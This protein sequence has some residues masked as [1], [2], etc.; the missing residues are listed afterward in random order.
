MPTVLDSFIVEFGLDPSKFTQGQRDVL[1]QVRKL[2]EQVHKQST[3]AESD[4]KKT[5]AMFTNL[6][7]EAL[8]VLS[9]FFGGKEVGEF[10][11][12]ITD[13][14]ASTGRLATT[15]GMSAQQVSAWQGAIR[16]T[17][18]SAEEANGALAGLSAEISRFSMTGRS[19]ML[20]VLARLGIDL[21]DSNHRLKTSGELW[22]ELADA[23]KAMDPRD[24][25]AFLQMIPGATQSMINF[26]LQGREAMERMLEKQR[27]IGV[28]TAESVEFAKEYQEAT[29]NLE[30]AWDS[31]GRT[32]T[33]RVGPA[34]TWVLNLM[35]MVL[36][37]AP[38]PRQLSAAEI[39]L[40]TTPG[41][42]SESEMEAARRLLAQKLRARSPS[43]GENWDRFLG[44]LSFLE[45][46]QRDVANP[47]SSAR[48]FFQFLSGTSKKAISAG[49]QDPSVGTYQDQ[50]EATRQYIRHFYPA[51][52]AAIERG[53]FPAATVMLRKEW[54]SLP[55]GSQ[56]QSAR[57][58]S[59]FQRYLQG[60][61]GGGPSPAG[62]PRREGEA[63]SGG[64][65]S[66][67][68]PFQPRGEAIGS[69][70]GTRY[71][72]FFQRY[73]GREEGAAQPPSRNVTV[74]VGGVTVNDQSGNAD[75]IAGNISGA[76]ERSVRAGLAN[77]GA[78]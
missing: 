50:A 42:A 8:G 24:A 59:E 34:L 78:N 69:E 44:G 15:L 6:K 64:P 74:N 63:E 60:E 47:T 65:V 68:S 52:A 58:Y 40:P 10:I 16:A 71:S 49:L 3:D 13:L 62:R 33:T 27:Q 67:Y 53:D 30:N 25:V 20:P 32:I 70:G 11:R 39:G 56:A 76:L 14:D 36:G 66:R 77:S 2:G 43:G 48:G 38:L 18:G 7:R 5:F 75:S 1:D 35:T 73:T 12:H 45:T 21:Y 28:A 29:K 37:K 41:K 4:V 72:Q 17:G 31:F 61:V 54:P 23:V 26:A 55:G 46:D 51:A 57:R 22:L 19:E 9:I